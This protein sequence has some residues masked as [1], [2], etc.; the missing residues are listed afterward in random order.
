MGLSRRQRAPGGLIAWPRAAQAAERVPWASSV[1]GARPLP[2][3]RLSMLFIWLKQVFEEFAGQ[4]WQDAGSNDSSPCRRRTSADGSRLRIPSAQHAEWL[5][6][7]LGGP[8]GFACWCRVCFFALVHLHDMRVWCAWMSMR[9]GLASQGSCA[10]WFGT[11]PAPRPPTLCML[12]R[13]MACHVF[14]HVSYLYRLSRRGVQESSMS[15]LRAP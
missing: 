10:G 9:V 1:G 5:G 8:G 12:V 6:G 14:V 4:Q 13:S 3:L 15:V 2:P 7:V 11:A